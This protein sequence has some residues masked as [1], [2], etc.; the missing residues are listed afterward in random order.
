MIWEKSG[1]AEGQERCDYSVD[2]CD[3]PSLNAAGKTDHHA[4]PGT[5]NE[6]NLPFTRAGGWR[7][8]GG[9]QKKKDEGWTARAN[10]LNCP[11]LIETHQRVASSSP[12]PGHCP[13][14][15][16][17]VCPPS[18]SG[19]AEQ[20]TPAKTANTKSNLEYHL[21]TKRSSA[22]AS[23]RGVNTTT[24][25]RYDQK[26]TIAINAFNNCARCATRTDHWA[27]QQEKEPRI[28]PLERPN[29][30][31]HRDVPSSQPTP[32]RQEPALSTGNA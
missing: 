20:A 23:N 24:G 9:R 27:F 6:C 19:S 4:V 31:L 30:D 2:R 5:R 26:P 32:Q 15:G 3:P 18:H 12:S 21:N 1:P 13:V 8:A 22:P 14:S 29:P 28:S 17:G 16:S 7:R 10:G 25:R 11:P